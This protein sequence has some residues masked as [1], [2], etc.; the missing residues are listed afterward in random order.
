MWRKFVKAL[1]WIGHGN[2]AVQVAGWAGIPTA[3]FAGFAVTFFSSAVDG[4]SVTAVWIASV[5]TGTL[6]AVLYAALM[7]GLAYR[8]NKDSS[9]GEYEGK[10]SNRLLPNNAPATVRADETFGFGQTIY[11]ESRSIKAPDGRETR[12]YETKFYIVVSN[13]SED[14]KTLRDVQAEIHGYET[15]V[16]AGIRGFAFDKIDL[17]HGQTAFF[18]LGRTIGTD[19][20]GNFVGD[21]TYENDRLKQYDHN[22]ASGRKPT[23]EVWSVDNVYRYGLNDPP[24]STGWKLLVLISAEDKKSKQI[25]LDINPVNQIPVSYEKGRA[26]VEK[27]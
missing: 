23:F 7:I 12:L 19:Y 18:F 26:T 10:D 15:P 9:K 2:T 13:A 8:R 11:Y 6:L 14:G 22:I 16:L 3:G 27:E 17:K 5:A 1:E 21:T 25:I 20:L 24:P 4:W